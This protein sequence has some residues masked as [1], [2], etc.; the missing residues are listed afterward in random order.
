MRV[1]VAIVVESVNDNV[2]ESIKHLLGMDFTDFEILLLLSTPSD[3]SFPQTRFIVR[4]DLAGNPALRRDLVITEAEGEILAFL[5]DD[6]YP[7]PSWLDSALPH[8]DDPRVAAVGGPGVTP[9]EDDW[10]RQ[11]SGWVHTSP[12]GAGSFSFRTKADKARQVDD[13][14]SMNLLVRK[15]DFALIGGFD[16][17]FWPGEDTKLCLD[18]TYKINKKII[19]EPR[20]LVYHHRRPIFKAHLVQVG[21][22]GLHRGYFA[23]VLPKTSRRVAYFLPSVLVLSFGIGLAAVLLAWVMGIKYILAGLLNIPLIYVSFV[24]PYFLLL[25]VNGLWIWKASGSF[26]AGFWSVP[27]VGL[28]HFWYGI[29][30]LRGLLSGKL[31]KYNNFSKPA[32]V[33]K[34]LVEVPAFKTQG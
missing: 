23:R 3:E 16:S 26:K 22:Y 14:P 25:L 31:M 4:P 21:R 13:F 15:S 29:Q 20:A 28:T 27:A 24:S 33:V 17:N 30:F 10:R 1:T 34:K 32:G 7:S 12:V 9:P 19:Y 18:L 2:R 5:D 8:F 6:A 11:V